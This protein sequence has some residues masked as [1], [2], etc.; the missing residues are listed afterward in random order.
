V[1]RKKGKSGKKI[2]PEFASRLDRLEPG[3]KV[4][5]IVLLRTGQVDD[6]SG[7]RQSSQERAEAVEA[8]RHAA[9]QA[10]TNI[11]SILVRHDGQRL[12]KSPDA[13]GSMPV[14]TTAAG[15]KAL[16]RSKWVEAVLEDQAIQL[17]F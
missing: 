10:L 8:M 4:Q 1:T 9:E 5:A 11:D 16:A 7:G 14:E 3:E 15:I 6:P 13:L 12:A 2:S 17:T